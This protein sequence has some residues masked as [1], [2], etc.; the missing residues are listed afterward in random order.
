MAALMGATLNGETSMMTSANSGAISIAA[1][2]GNVVTDKA[3]GDPM[4]PTWG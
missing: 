4:F 3:A 1:A 2:G